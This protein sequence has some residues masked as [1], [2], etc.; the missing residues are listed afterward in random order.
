MNILARLLRRIMAA[1]LCVAPLAATLAG[2]DDVLRTTFAKHGA[3]MLFIAPDSGRIID[4]NE[5][6]T[7]FYGYP[8]DKLLGMRIQ[9]INTLGPDEVA[10]ERAKAISENR[11]YFIFPHRLASGELRTVEVYS[12]PIP[13]ERHGT[14]LFSIVHDISGKRVTEAAQLEY[15]K[16]LAALAEQRMRETMTARAWIEWLLFGG[17]LV[18][19]LLNLLLYRNIQQKRLA[20]EQRQTALSELARSNADLQRF[21]E[22]TAHHLQ[23]PA[24]RVASYAERLGKQLAGK[25]A[26]PEARLSLDFI[27]QQARRQQ[28]LL[29]DVERYLAADQPR[30]KLHLSDAT[31]S[32]AYACDKLAAKLA[33]QPVEVNVGPLPPAWI[34]TARLNDLFEIALD[35]ALMHGGTKSRF[36]QD[37]KEKLVITIDGERTG[38]QVRYRVSDNGPGIEPEYRERVFG[39][40]EKLGTGSAS[41]GIGMR[42]GLKG[43]QAG[44]DVAAPVLKRSEDRTRYF[45]FNVS[46]LSPLRG[47]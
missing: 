19:A 32:I 25:L 20:L 8:L 5:A 3:V 1:L 15:E 23:E 46:G 44:I 12:S 43:V 37:G 35:N 31:K 18:T 14:A 7:R 41:T 39:V 11:N 38:A 40:F 13:L 6:A 9:D 17:L 29:R 4:A 27:G 28:A 22:V 34:D 21:A 45:H 16:K 33:G 26:D 10:A 36:S 2:D 47:F 24:R 42:L 30:G